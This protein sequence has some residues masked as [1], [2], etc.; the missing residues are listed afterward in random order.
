MRAIASLGVSLFAVLLASAA[1][2]PDSVVPVAVTRSPLLAPDDAAN[3][4]TIYRN[5]SSSFFRSGANPNDV[6]ES[7]TVVPNGRPLELLR[8]ETALVVTAPAAVV[9][10]IRIWD[11]F[12]AGASPVHSGLLAEKS[13]DLGPDPLPVGLRIAQA[14]IYP[15]VPL[16]DPD[17]GVQLTFLDRGTGLPVARGAVTVAF[18][19]QGVAIGASADTYYR[20]ANGTGS[21]EPSDA[22]S[23]GGSSRL[24]NF[25]LH[26]EGRAVESRVDAG[27]LLF[28]T[29]GGGTTLLGDD[30]NAIG[31]Y[32]D[33][34]D[35]GARCV[36]ASSSCD[37]TFEFCSA[38]MQVGIPLVGEP[39]A[40]SADLA[41]ADTILELMASATLPNPGDSASVP[42]RLAARS[43][44]SERP[45]VVSY[46]DGSG[47]T[48]D[49]LWTVH[50]CNSPS[51]LPAVGSVEFVR[52]ACAGSGGTFSANLEFFPKVTL[53]PLADGGATCPGPVT[54]DYVA[55]GVPALPFV[56]AGP[57]SADPP[58]GVEAAAAAPGPVAVDC[59]GVR[60]DV[61]SRT[62]PLFAGA[63]S[64]RCAGEP[65]GE[66]RASLARLL[67]GG[68][69]R[70]PQGLLLA[71]APAADSDGDGIADAM[72][73]CPT[74]ANPLQDDD[75]DGDGIGS[76]CDDCP[77]ACDPD[78]V[79]ADGDGVGD[80]CDCAPSDPTDPP[81]EIASLVAQDRSRFVWASLPGAVAYD[82]VR[83]SIPAL[84]VGPGGGDEQCLAVVGT[85]SFED[86]GAPLPGGSFY[87]VRALGSCG[88]GTYGLTH[89]NPGPSENGPAR[90]SATCP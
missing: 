78:Q 23:F 46:F 35:N 30:L 43:L 75:A 85:P 51:A 26:L 45:I 54:F 34:D 38:G 88:T 33:L 44:R 69:P 50:V 64:F 90:I 60:D 86:P 83:G 15:A 2:A 8:I 63:S 67:V 10:R 72:D 24:A 40:A 32:F 22:R 41:G 82:V 21:F 7:L 52:G 1:P 27:S 73:S 37:P 47:G 31:I 56:I 11:V 5:E 68:T 74:F 76:T 14:T 17:I 62:T 42:A 59:D 18:A 53:V 19:G 6:Y 70:M 13:I 66:P 79:D 89:A 49:T 39:L 48:V 65:C 84:P 9:L 20:D 57:W 80:A 29:P 4:A 81:G 3:S 71:A 87:V 61:L 28:V 58:L 77:D 16:S 25:Y 55:W 36:P 12:D